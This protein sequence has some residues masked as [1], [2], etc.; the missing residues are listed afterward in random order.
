[1][2]TSVT[3][4]TGLTTVASYDYR[5]LA[6]WQ[7]IDANENQQQTLLDALARV[8][9][10]PFF[11]K[12]LASDGSPAVL[13]GFAPIADFNGDALPMTSID[14]ALAD[15]EGALQQAP[16]VS[17]YE[18]YSWMGRVAVW[19]LF[20]YLDPS[21][22]PSLRRTLQQ[23]H[24]ITA[25]G[26]ILSAGRRWANGG[27]DIPGIPATMRA[28]F[29]ATPRSPLHNAVQSAE[30]FSISPAP[31]TQ[32]IQVVLALALGS[33]DPCKPSRGPF[34]ARPMSS[35]TIV[36]SGWM[37]PVNRWSG[38]L[39]KIGG[40]QFRGVWTMIKMGCRCDVT[41]RILSINHVT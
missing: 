15:P 14:A 41:S 12:Q 13:V 32:Q 39:P 30:Q 5:F 38:T 22:V 1:V 21:A 34:R 25:A 9:A 7:M 4:A 40:G 11:G 31:E 36:S 26:H 8:V 18:L 37:V 6:P 2:I 3:N 29:K 33:D 27:A 16:T 19:Q 28:V 24:L 35:T 23:L 20:V 17:L 10:T